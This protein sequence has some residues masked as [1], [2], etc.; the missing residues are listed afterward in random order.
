MK[1]VTAK[2]VVAQMVYLPVAWDVPKEVGIRYQMCSNSPTVQAHSAI[3]SSPAGTR[4]WARP[5][6]AHRRYAPNYGSVIHD[7]ASLMDTLN[8]FSTTILEHGQMLM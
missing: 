3:A 5:L 1:G 8:D 2:P 6:V 7:D 4:G